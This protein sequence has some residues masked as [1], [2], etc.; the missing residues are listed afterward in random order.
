VERQVRWPPLSLL[1]LL[2]LV[3]VVPISSAPANGSSSG[4]A[5]RPLLTAVMAPEFGAPEKAAF[6]HARAAGAGFVRLV[7]WWPG[8]A[9]RSEPPASFAA[10][11][12]SD[13]QYSW[14][15][16][17]DS[18]RSA[19]AAGL[20]P[21][22]DIIGAPSWA[23]S[24][25][26]QRP[27]DGPVRP[28]PAALGDF[29]TA[30]AR[31]Y[32]G[33]FRGLPRVRYWQV[34][35]EPNLSIQLMPQSANGKPVSPDRYR[36]M[37]NAMAKA[38]HAVRRDNVV[39]AG[40]LAPFG[41]DVNDPSGGKVPDQERVRPMEF[42]RRFLCMS[43]SADPKPTCDQKVEFDIWGH[44]PYT[45]GGPTHKAFHADDV[46]LGDLDKMRRLLNAAAR[47]NHI[48]SRGEVGFWVTEFSYDSQPADPKGLP[49]LLHARWVSE[50]LYRMWSDGVTLVTWFLIR[51]EPFPQGMYQSGFYTKDD[52]PKLAL[53][54]F[55]FPFVAFRKKN[56]SI[57]YWGRTPAGVRKAVVVEQE[58]GAGWRGVVI[59]SVDR[60]GIFS[61]TIDDVRGSGSLRARL[62]SRGDFSQPF[63]LT[64]PKDFRF[65]PWGSFC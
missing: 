52:R 39:I 29:A 34:W 1:V 63:S 53:R 5:A 23:Q 25:I 9:P 24:G 60:Y 20:Q 37:V 57:S 47:A 45:Y 56:G 36:A 59:P 43:K 19:V 40:G 27:S 62:A 48:K 16:L 54:A 18:V 21:I 2:A 44:H 55:R 22:V 64:V 42:M 8:V 6:Q 46:S 30:L 4:R 3:V 41:G 58:A 26:A 11:N 35:N 51:D 15:A 65:C 31:R 61:G 50:A 10:R 28:S 12:P 38:V 32:S 7:L 49:P 14:Q 17:D 33:G 13:P